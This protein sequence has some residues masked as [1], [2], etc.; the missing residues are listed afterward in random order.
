MNLPLQSA[1]R[2]PHAAEPAF[3]RDVL[4]GLAQARKSVPCAW[5]YDRQGSD[6]FE[7]ITRVPEYYPTRTETL[8]LQ[9][10]A[11]EIGALAGPGACVVELGSGSS[12]KTP[13]LLQALQA[14]SA[15]VPVDISAQFLRESVA[16]LQPR[17]PGLPMHPL[18]ADFR[19]LGVLPA[20]PGAR[21]LLFF[22]G[23]TIGNLAPEEAAVLLRRLALLAGPGGLL[24][25]GADATQD[26]ALLLPAYDDAQGVTAAFNL[27]LLRRI[28]RELGADFDL[29]SFRHAARFDTRER[30]VEMHLVSRR[31]QWVHVAGAAFR[32]L[33]G[34]SIHT[35]NSYKYGP[36][37]LQQMAAAAGW[38]QHQHWTDAHA[39]FSVHVFGH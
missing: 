16:A 22:P 13:L 35:E 1:P 9:R 21:R 3:L 19:H 26:P 15:Y 25:L 6:L 8:I 34:E 4:A 28:N 29:G 31:D 24:V 37:R 33:Q 11:G 27:N 18:V 39:R 10:C 20:P 7:Q 32:F 2:T 14:P 38:Q 12:A 23:S 30:R 36:Q 5:L 17:F